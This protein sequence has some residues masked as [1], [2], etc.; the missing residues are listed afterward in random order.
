MYYL[1]MA[2]RAE[3]CK[4]EVVFWWMIEGIYELTQHDAFPK[5]FIMFIIN[6]NYLLP[7]NYSTMFKM[8]PVYIFLNVWNR[9]KVFF[10]G[11]QGKWFR[12]GGTS[13][14]HIMPSHFLAMCSIPL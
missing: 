6:I 13:F 8:H 2:L 5:D 10:L 3:T 14:L 11:Q 9:E 1:R 7:K 4:N 12:L